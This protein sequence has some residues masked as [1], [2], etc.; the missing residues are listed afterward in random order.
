VIEC[1]GCG[2]TDEAACE[3]GCSWSLINDEAGLGI[4]SSCFD[5]FDDPVARLAEAAAGEAPRWEDDS[6]DA[7]ESPLIL[8]GDP[9]Y[10]L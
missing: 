4:C 10:H 3:G 5:A 8:P 6:E 7:R 1:I 9:E 2:C